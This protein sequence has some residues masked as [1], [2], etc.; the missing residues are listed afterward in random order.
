MSARVLAYL[1]LL[2]LPTVFTALA[3]IFLGFLLTHPALTSDEGPN[4]LPAFLLLCAASA[5]LYLSGMVFNDYFDRL[6]DAEERPN[7]SIPSGAISPVAALRLGGALM[8][9][10]LVAAACV[11]LPSVLVAV[12]LCALVLGYDGG[13]K[14]TPL[15]PLLM[16]S[17]RVGNVLLGASAVT[18]IADVFQKPQLPIALGLGLYIVGVTLF[19]RQEARTSRR[20]GLLMAAVVINVGVGSLAWYVHS[21]APESHRL[22]AVLI[23]AMILFTL[24]RRLAVAI[25]Q[26]SPQVVQLAIKVLLLSLVILDATLIVAFNGNIEA[27]ML[28]VALLIPAFGLSRVIAMT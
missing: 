4:P 25:A 10:G 19:A 3:D 20:S 22:S 21:A 7:R 9:I 6:I 13:L 18:T 15:G 1:R 5:G 26:P 23:L 2:R 11:G 27:A 17:C 28:T 12:A 24:D 8:L 16:G 14:K